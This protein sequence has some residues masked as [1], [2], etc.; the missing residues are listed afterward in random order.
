MKPSRRLISQRGQA[1]TE[2]IL[3]VIVL[4]SVS[5]MASQY[6][7]NNEVLKKLIKGPFT[8]LSG[9]L[10][11]GVWASPQQGAASHPTAHGRHIVIQG[12]PA[13]G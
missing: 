13:S 2:A 1:V 3:I 12:E 4:A 11:N 10:Q 9:L 7:K 6:F 5:L 8:A